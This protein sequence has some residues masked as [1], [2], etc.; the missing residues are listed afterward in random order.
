M[1]I[2][3]VVLLVVFGLLTLF[4]VFNWG[5]ITAPTSLSL[6]IADVQAP[7]GLVLLGFVLLLT[8][9]FLL[10]ALYL[11]TSVL[12]E[13]HRHGKEL[14][15]Q[16]QLA[17]Q[18]EA[19]RFT[20]LRNYL[21]GEVAGLKQAQEATRSEVLGRLDRLEEGLRD[22]VEQSGTSLSA[23]IGEL[24]DRVERQ[25]LPDVARAD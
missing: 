4:V 3:N 13:S 17:D 5:A 18:A 11:R 24:E 21:A 23:Y 19:S 9:L 10:F 7:L 14:K 20:E 12:M 22:A 1:P 8:L 2:R 25:A 15:A 16:R 6:G